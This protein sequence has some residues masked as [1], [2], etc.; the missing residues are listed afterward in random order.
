MGRKLNSK[1]CSQGYVYA[2]CDNTA[3]KTT[4]DL[5]K[6]QTSKVLLT[7]SQEYSLLWGISSRFISFSFV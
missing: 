5:A 7:E 3:R 2:R 1:D 4:T 6:Q